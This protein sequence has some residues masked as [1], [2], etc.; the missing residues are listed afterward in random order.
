MRG[1]HALYYIMC[2]FHGAVEPSS[3]LQ[4]GGFFTRG[5]CPLAPTAV[6]TSRG[7]V[8]WIFVMIFWCR[9]SLVCGAGQGATFSLLV[10]A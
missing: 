5:L 3:D 1:N 10:A 9:C 7:V 2:V 4:C 8:G 6:L